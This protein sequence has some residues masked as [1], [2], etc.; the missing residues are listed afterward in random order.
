M[1]QELGETHQEQNY[2][3]FCDFFEPVWKKMDSFIKEVDEFR[4]YL[5]EEKKILEEYIDAG[6][7]PI[8]R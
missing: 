7:K 3:Q 1:L 5:D 2:K 6:N 4:S 8:M